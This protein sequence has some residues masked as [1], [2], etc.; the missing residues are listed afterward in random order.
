M[1]AAGIAV[2]RYQR[3]TCGKQV[4]NTVDRHDWEFG[5][6]YIDE[7]VPLAKKKFVDAARMDTRTDCCRRCGV[8]RIADRYGK[9][10]YYQNGGQTIP[11]NRIPNCK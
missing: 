2:G 4:I 7:A 5:I 11:P 10:M 3:H 1:E 8:K 6:Q 9:V